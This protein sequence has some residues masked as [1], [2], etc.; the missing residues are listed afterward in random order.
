MSI[1]EPIHEILHLDPQRQK[2]GH[3]A[4]MV[5]NRQPRLSIAASFRNLSLYLN[6]MQKRL[7]RTLL[8]LRVAILSDNSCANL[9]H[10]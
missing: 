5:A 4:F 7:C 8:G 1:P 6:V 9:I 2:S 10:K 3:T